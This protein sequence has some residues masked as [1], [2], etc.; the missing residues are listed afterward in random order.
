MASRP[1]ESLPVLLAGLKLDGEPAGWRE[2]VPR[3]LEAAEREAYDRD[4][5]RILRHATGH[6]M[7]AL[8]GRVPASVVV[9]AVRAAA[10]VRS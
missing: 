2:L 9:L 1:G 4:P 8:R 5:A 3:W 10:T 7:E 6:A